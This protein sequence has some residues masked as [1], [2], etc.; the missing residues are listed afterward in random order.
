MRAASQ[1]CGRGSP[2]AAPGRRDRGS[3]TAELAAGLPAVAVL[4][5][6]GLTA[7]SAVTTRMECVDA[8]REVALAV[9]RGEPAETV[10]HGAPDNARVSVDIRGETVHATVRAR[11]PLLGTRLPA[12][13]VAGAAVA[14]LE[15]GS[16]APV[17]PAGP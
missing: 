7:V 6:A 10:V 1:R 11:V 9:A 16:P 13:T 15:P 8:A 17:P 5:L 12:L 2:P 4:L 3:T 14:A